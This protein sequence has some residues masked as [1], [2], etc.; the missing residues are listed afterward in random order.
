MSKNSTFLNKKFKSV[1]DKLEFIQKNSN[2]TELFPELKQLFKDKGYDK[3]II[4]HGNEEYGKDL[5][6]CKYDKD[7]KQ[8]V[9]HAVI[10]KN[11]KATQ[12][13]F[14]PGNEIGNQINNSFQ[15]PY[16]DDLGNEKYISSVIIVINSVVTGNATEV[17]KTN[18]TPV[19]KNNIYIWNYQRLADEFEEYSKETFLNN[20]DPAISHYQNQ[21]IKELSNIDYNSILDLK[22][23]DINEIFVNVQT[24]YSREVRKLNEYITYDAED[25]KPFKDEDIEG[26]S[27]IL[28]SN[29]NFVVHGIPTSGK[30]ILL[31][32]IG[33]K[34]LTNQEANYA[35]FYIE[36]D[37]VASFDINQLIESDYQRISK[38]KLERQDY[39]KIILLIDSIDFLNNIDNKKYVLQQ[40]ED[41]SKNKNYQII[42]ATRDY[43]YLKSLGFLND[44]KETELLPFNL[45]QALKLVK[46][47][48][49][50]NDVK[51]NNFVNAIKERL[52][53]S[54]LQKTP[55]ALT[56]LAVL[57]RD[58]QIDLKEL[59]AN[60]F[61][62]YNKFT[63][64]YLDRWDANKGITQQYKYE[65]TKII[66]SFLALKLHE[67][68][69]STISI[70]ELEGFLSDLRGDY[71]FDELDD[72]ESYIEF[73]KT[74]SG[75]FYY[76]ENTGCF[77]FFNHFFQEFFTSLAI[78]DDKDGIFIDKF[79]NQWWHNSLIFYA[80][81][82]PKS[83]KIHKTIL[84]KILPIDTLQRLMYLSQHSKSL[85]ASHS[86]TIK[87]REEVVNKLLFEFNELFR[88]LF[89][90]AEEDKNSLL[91]QF[92][93]VSV[94]NQSKNLFEEFFNSKHIA[95]SEILQ[96]LEGE[97]QNDDLEQITKYNIAYFISYKRNSH[98]A[99]ETFAEQI[100]E[101]DNPIWSRILYVDVNFLK[102]KKSIDQK[103]LVRIKRKMNKNKFLIQHLLKNNIYNTK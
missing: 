33:I 77:T 99:L 4:T 10:V 21:M 11:K 49:P 54:S 36:L 94:I 96:K 86:I 89:I 44:F 71:N 23:T 90:E 9:W 70:T 83:F 74:K 6:V 52:L 64:V 15:V 32:R 85:Q 92:S 84:S 1:S 61:E 47:I 100:V 51:A 48:I 56:L 24:T 75:V 14:L 26:S 69:V 46:K 31:K 103:L 82:S 22:I 101:I 57:Y 39:E 25:Q 45:G 80:G 78:E 88:N 8:E 87:Q 58:E 5:V 12:N 40:I 13:D 43:N 67:E 38:E 97:L 63:D 27:E 91:N 60:I 102:Y 53:N 95:T 66:I 34:A 55:L 62:L 81:R 30:T 29:H 72:I 16:K 59:P 73:L 35:V 28:N 65:Q 2:E 18:Y 98:K 37:K 76:D 20:L 79:F 7:L 17:I 42:V 19:M 93:L 41:F 50:N 68:E 3:V